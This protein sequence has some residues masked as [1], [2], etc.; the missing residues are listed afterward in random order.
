MTT[1]EKI[2]SLIEKSASDF[3]DQIP[4]LQ[5]QLYK[6]LVKEVQ[7]LQT[8]EGNILS[9]VENLKLIGTIRNKLEK[10]ILNED[11]LKNVGNYVQAFDAVT[12]LQIQ[13]FQEFNNKFRP[14]K[15]LKIVQDL[16]IEA[17]LNS[18]TEAGINVNVLEPVKELL[19]ANII[20]GG[21]IS[22]LMEGLRKRIVSDGNDLGA[23]ERYTKQ[24]TTDALN[25]YSAQY[26]NTVSEDLGLEWYRYIGSLITTSRE[27]CIY[28][29][30]KEWVHKSELPE[31]VKGNID[32]HKCQLNKKTGLPLGMI[33]ETNEGNFMI[34]RAGYQ[35]GHQFFGVPTVSV[36][37]SIVNSLP[38]K[39]Q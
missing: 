34:F 27:F 10:I 23:L 4:G 16:A 22:D 24:I 19:K 26:H 17:T 28:L 31:I 5:K 14:K 32:G 38:H 30:K 9:N 25:Q 12:A 3:N 33:S 20:G 11:Y 1:A 37:S 8:R 6:D 29:T 36:P 18:L 15:T 7:K 35:C 13:Y 39:H 21:N 2:L